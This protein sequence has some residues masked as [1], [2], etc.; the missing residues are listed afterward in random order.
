MNGYGT[1]LARIHHEGFGD[2]ARAAAATL[3]DELRRAGHTDGRIVDLGCGS[4]ILARIAS[5]AGYEVLGVDLSEA[6]LELASRTAPR[7]CFVRASI[8]DVAIPPAVAVCA[9]GECFNYAFDARASLDAFDSRARAIHAALAPRGIFLLDLAGPGRVG[10]TPTEQSF[11]RGEW[12][13]RVRAEEDPADRTLTRRIA[14]VPRGGSGAVRQEE[15]HVL[16]LYAPADV[17][18]ALADAGFESV[19]LDGYAGLSLGRGWSAYR[20]RRPE[21]RRSPLRPSDTL[22]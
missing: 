5:E 21:L 16:R 3:L 15:T 18:S 19:R 8:L 7:A 11:E 13:I 1:L 10:A 20:A 14:L 22:C 17:E 2:V 12:T 6:M 4:G 9:V